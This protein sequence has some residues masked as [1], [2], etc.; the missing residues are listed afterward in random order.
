[1]A[2]QLNVNLNFTADTSQA[3]NNLKS[4]KT[5][6]ETIGAQGNL[7]GPNKMNDS[8][9]K[10]VVS[11]KDLSQ[12]LAN[13]FNP[14]TGNLNLNKFE[15]SLQ[16]SGQT[17]K[18]L[19]ND[20]LGAGHN[21]QKAFMNLQN[22]IANANLQLNKTQTLLGSFATTFMN[23]V[24][25][26][27][28]SSM[29]HG[30]SS[31][32]S[33]ALGYAQKLNKS[34]TDI[35][36]VAPEKSIGD[37]AD[38][39]KIANQQAKELSTST[40]DYVDGALI[41][42]QQ[43]LS[44]LETKARTDVTMKMKNVTGDSAE[45]VSSY[46]T[47]IW[48]NFNK[49]GQESEEHYADILAKLG[50]DTAASTT[51]ITSALEK[52]SAVADTIG[53]SYEAA[54]AA[55]T[56]L[57]DRTREAPEVA[58]TALKTVFA[59]LQ[60]LK[61]NGEVTDEDGVTTDLN[62]YSTGLAS[63]GVQIKDA[64]GELKNADIILEE[65]GE[66]WKTLDRDQQVALA[67]T[68]A[69]LRQYNQFAALM[70]NYDYYEKYKEI[71]ETGSDGTLQEQQDIYAESW[72]AA[73][74]RVKAAFETIYAS[75][76]SDQTFIKLTDA[77][78]G[79]IEAI[80]IVTD[81]IGGL[82]GVL[83]LIAGL[84]AKAFSGNIAAGL[85]NATERLN[86]GL[87]NTIDS[88]KNLKS[89]ILNLKSDHFVKIYNEV[90][91]G[92]EAFQRQSQ[93]VLRFAKEV[94]NVPKYFHQWAE[95][96]ERS[97]ALTAQMNALGSKISSTEREKIQASINQ[98]NIL[99][100]QN[101]ETNRKLQLQ[102]E[103]LDT[104]TAEVVASSKSKDALRPKIKINELLLKIEKE[105][106]QIK[107]LSE[108]TDEEEIAIYS[109]QYEKL[110]EKVRAQ[111]QLTTQE[112]IQFRILEELALGEEKLV[113]IIARRKKVLAD[114]V[115][116]LGVQKRQWEE[117]NRQQYEKINLE[118]ESLVNNERIVHIQKTVADTIRQIAQRSQNFIGMIPGMIHGL[119]SAALSASMVKDAIE[120]IQSPD[121]SGFE[122]FVSATM[123]ASF[124]VGTLTSAYQGLQG[125]CKAAMIAEQAEIETRLLGNVVRQAS[126]TAE[127]E[128]AIIK[129]GQILVTKNLTDEEIKETLISAT[130]GKITWEE[131]KAH[132]G[133]SNA[134]GLETVATNTLANANK[135]LMM[136]AVGVLGP[137]VGVIT[138]LGL[139]GVG[140]YAVYKESHQ[141]RSAYKD[142]S[143]TNNELVESCNASI[144]KLN[145][146]SDS[147]ENLKSKA[148]ELNGVEIGSTKWTKEISEHNESVKQLI[149]DYNELNDV[150][151]AQK[152]DSGSGT[153]SKYL[154]TVNKKLEKE[155]LDTTDTLDLVAGE[156]YITT[157]GV[158]E[159]TQAGEIKINTVSAISLQ[160]AQIAISSADIVTNK[161]EEAADLE[162]IASKYNLGTTGTGYYYDAVAQ[163]FKINRELDTQDVLRIVRDAAVKDDEFSS[164]NLADKDWYKENTNL[165]DTIIE[166]LTS[167]KNSEQIQRD[168]YAM[169]C[170]MKDNSDQQLLNNEQLISQNETI[171]KGIAKG[172]SEEDQEQFGTGINTRMSEDMQ[173][174][175]ERRSAWGVDKLVEKSSYGTEVDAKTAFADASGLSYDKVEDKYYKID[176]ETKEK[177]GKG[178]DASEYEK[179]LK[180]FLAT[181]QAVDQLEKNYKKYTDEV[182]DSKNDWKALDKIKEKYEEQK[183]ALK[184]VNE[185]IEGLKEKGKK[186]S[187]NKLSP[188]S[189]KAIDKFA[190]DTKESLA[191]ALDVG[192]DKNNILN[193]DFYTK[194]LDKIK[195]AMKGD[196]KAL[197]K[198]RNAY[199]I[200]DVK[201]EALKVEPEIEI[202]NSK[203]KNAM[204]DLQSVLDTIPLN[205]KIDIDT[206]GARD[207]INSLL[208]TMTSAANTYDSTAKGMVGSAKSAQ[209]AI[210]ALA[211]AGVEGISQNDLEW[212][213]LP[214]Q[215]GEEKVETT[216]EGLEAEV[217][218]IPMNLPVANVKTSGSEGNM[219]IL[220]SAG[221]GPTV[222]IPTFTY[223]SSGSETVKST[224]KKTTSHMGYWK[225]TGKGGT[226]SNNGG[227]IPRGAG[228]SPSTPPRGGGGGG[229]GGGGRGGGRRSRPARRQLK[230]SKVDRYKDVTQKIEKV[231]RAAEKLQDS[232]E[233]LYGKKRLN[234]MDKVN[235]KLKE[236]LKYINEKNVRTRK[237]LELDRKRLQQDY[238]ALKNQLKKSK[239]KIKIGIADF[240]FDSTGR[241]NN[242][243]T[244]MDKL[245][246]EL[247]KHVDKMNKQK[248]ED[249][250]NAYKEKYI[251]PIE[252]T[253]DGI[254]SLVDQYEE[255]Y[256]E[257]LSQI[258]DWQDKYNEILDNNYEKITYQIEL[259]TTI[260]DNAESLL[261]YYLD[262]IEDSSYKV[263]ELFNL[264]FGSEGQLAQIE[265]KIG[266]YT[267][268][269]F[270]DAISG[271]KVDYLQHLSD[272]Y[273]AGEITQASY[274]EGLQEEYDAMLDNLSALSDL[275]DNMD[276][277]YNNI[278]SEVQDEIDKYTQSVEYAAQAL[279]HWRNLIELTGD[280]KEYNQLIMIQKQLRDN[281]EQTYNN[282]ITYYNELIKNV[283]E[284]KEK[285]VSLLPTYD[286]EQL[287]KYQEELNSMIAAAEEAGDQVMS[288]YE[289]LLETAQEL[290]ELELEQAN[291]TIDEL[292]S[293]V[294]GGFEELTRIMDLTSTG[295]DE[296]LTKTNQIYEMNKLLRNLRTDMDKTEN[297]SAKQRLNNFAKELEQLKQ[298]DELSQLELDIA[299]AKYKQLQAQIA[300]EEAQNAKQTIRLSR[301]N[302]GNYGY[303]YTANEDA[304]NDAQ[305]ALDDASN[306]LYNIYLTGNNDYNEKIINYAQEM[307]QN[308]QEINENQELSQAEKDDRIEKIREQYGSLIGD[309]SDLVDIAKQ[310][311]INEFN[312]SG[313]AWTNKYDDNVSSILTN[314]SSGVDGWLDNINVIKDEFKDL[315]DKYKDLEQGII[316]TGL[317][318]GEEA[319]AALTGPDGV[320]AKGFEALDTSINNLIDYI[321]NDLPEI[322]NELS[323]LESLVRQIKDMIALEVNEGVQTYFNYNELIKYLSESQGSNGKQ[324]SYNTKLNAE[325]GRVLM[326]SSGNEFFTTPAENID[327]DA[328]A[329][330]IYQNYIK[331]GKHGVISYDKDGKLIFASSASGIVSDKEYTNLT[332]K[333]ADKDPNARI[334]RF[335]SGGYTGSW[336]GE[337]GKLALLD[338]K[339]L[340]LNEHDTQNLLSSVDII[341]R[342]VDQIDLQT[343]TNTI[344]GLTSTT[345]G[346]IDNSSSVDQNVVISADFPNVS[347]RD[348]IEA[349]FDNLINRAA[350]YSYRNK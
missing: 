231:N 119:S 345:I 266:I 220:S 228:S 133:C 59:R 327:N 141:M 17:L 296:Y 253:I 110:K 285:N 99:T 147:V 70:D 257:M 283:E 175:I 51:E 44:D 295:Q 65:I 12:H 8:L 299:E 342:V 3:E 329:E 87:N 333:L 98:A 4:L 118:R 45:D 34:L 271:E 121:A 234:N 242:Y 343:M 194:N 128:E 108:I 307:L 67:Q 217:D 27:V 214:D 336:N 153:K 320:F 42:Y 32:L 150:A 314:L 250:Q 265:N 26:Q 209:A 114:A 311:L 173:G 263:G 187:Y 52:Y 202:D 5:T 62:K 207:E 193:K 259:D 241:I 276:D 313:D 215:T 38:F 205:K 219:S 211:A 331:Q 338:K 318:L 309:A 212:V 57:I 256:E 156:D 50:A 66:K 56:T 274:V 37:M 90:N 294:A 306:E 186:I 55:A 154:K 107:S 58:G 134:K 92:T 177:T 127:E 218:S 281:A 347:S 264:Y 116:P 137:I 151:Q 255:T 164:I 168:I 316:D 81:G 273:L 226:V 252:E 132:L 282:S 288:D 46:M 155:G 278:L 249:K 75:L 88:L 325:G 143:E 82:K 308:I 129:A 293:G 247:D 262:K 289:N 188:A 78:G 85:Q 1:M 47:A 83:I 6:L 28:T 237:F 245:Q 140:I 290:L 84:A 169:V 197:E 286:E 89:N 222:Q 332:K 221:I 310:G 29:V 200:E 63:V 123:A 93:E 2:K 43:G 251:D 328:I 131:A 167:S 301:D 284:F 189:K 72:E 227:T 229:G 326:D 203:Y 49:N 277:Y 213:N 330:D 61:L 196:L 94:A 287:A 300:L 96:L 233:Q 280:G 270:D 230:E 142:I 149:N 101:V 139:L 20:L 40:L 340:V 125:L 272:S 291:K 176:P 18:G 319:Q 239:A 171:Q 152:T 195:K 312:A 305:Q 130:S 80:S 163:K 64:N 344:S 323:S 160:E 77:F 279:E 240:T 33:H 322:N 159:I 243:N 216:A 190:E 236:E 79:L 14:K 191:Q 10:A 120:T 324:V 206:A 24:R 335:A 105:M 341:R 48:N 180:T 73:S 165:S 339:E 126:A 13:A 269:K 144:D 199:E 223:N 246:N 122:K 181:E 198:I 182:K 337:Q 60:G 350:Q 157:N 254:Q 53:L 104:Y 346:N 297:K 103:S 267:D 30:I 349:A 68:V 192:D 97:N 348:E 184:G 25:W 248:N 22:S 268:K 201:K 174:I 260:S 9:Q 303:V 178:K 162:E 304:V 275:K 91:K 54:T 321:F 183:D 11:A 69:G 106:L 76:F 86:L 244:I 113:D 102:K 74:N 315:A 166:Q 35:R 117:I 148:E 334:L 124:A 208:S 238:D 111:E 100:E 170:N 23:T 15:Q 39:A 135:G 172:L 112:K 235:A 36:I 298:K 146:F 21:G 261:D 95:S 292:L 41:Y 232:Q 179:D 302:E 317:E 210:A 16:R 19:S 258:D 161:A 225:Y 115:R 204:K 31:A 158:W 145:T 71:A 109:K 224:T 138:A 7:L 185:E 136:S